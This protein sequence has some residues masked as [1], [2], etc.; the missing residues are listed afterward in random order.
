VGILGL[1]YVGLPLVRKGATIGANATVVCGN[2]LGEYSFIGAGAVVT[3]DVKPYALIVGNLGEQ[4]GWG[5]SCGNKLEPGD[6]K[7]LICACGKEYR[8][9]GDRL[10]KR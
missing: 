5:C 4:V 10:L 8:L 9:A 1:G 6:N 2:E 3:K 7:N